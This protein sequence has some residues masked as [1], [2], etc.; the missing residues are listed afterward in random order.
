[1]DV[2]DGSD[3]DYWC[4]STQLVCYAQAPAVGG[5]IYNTRVKI[6]ITWGKRDFNTGNITGGGQID[7]VYYGR[8]GSL[9]YGFRVHFVWDSGYSVDFTPGYTRLMR[10]SFP[11][12]S[13]VSRV[14]WDPGAVNT[15]N[16]NWYY[17]NSTSFSYLENAPCDSNSYN[18][19]N[20]LTGWSGAGM[21]N[22]DTAHYHTGRWR[23][24][25]RSASPSCALYWF[26][27]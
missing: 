23:I 27:Q 5:K 14:S 19:D 15:N 16:W 10:E 22:T 13:E 25:G 20:V 18:D 17:P 6:N 2:T 21:Y 9:R 11:S 12:D 26:S 3:D 7:V 1:M 8:G 24:T 4:E